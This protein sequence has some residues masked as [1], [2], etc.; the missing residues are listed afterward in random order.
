MADMSQGVGSQCDAR[1][2]TIR[3][4]ACG[5]GA[6]A[7]ITQDW[8]VRAADPQRPDVRQ[9]TGCGRGKVDGGVAHH[10]FQQSVSFNHRL[11]GPAY[12][13]LAV[14][15]LAPQAQIGKDKKKG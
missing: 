1:G 11:A 6:E 3:H 15:G 14:I 10:H 4:C 13:T 8:P 2:E 7:N 12:Q 5:A 9:Y